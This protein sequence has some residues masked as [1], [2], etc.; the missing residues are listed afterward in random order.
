MKRSSPTRTRGRAGFTLAEL[1]VVVSIL[2]ILLT[3]LC[4]IYLAMVMQWERQQGQGDALIATSRAFTTMS[5]ELSQAVSVDMIDHSGHNSAVVYTLP[6]DKDSSNQYY[7]PKWVGGSLQYRAGAKMAFYLSD[8][9]GQFDRNGNILWRG[10]VSGTYPF[11]GTISPDPSWDA[12]PQRGRIAPLDS[13]SFDTDNWAHP[14]RVTVT[15]TSSYVIRDSTTHMTRK[16]S[17]FLR[18]AN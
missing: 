18:N 7:V 17:I 8:S 13:L 2:S 12:D 10:V 5:S 14:V 3:S 11:S 6:L 4:G 1:L 15:A 9:T 16:L